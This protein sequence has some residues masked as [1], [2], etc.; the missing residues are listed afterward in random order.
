MYTHTK[1][2]YTSLSF[3]VG[4]AHV[5]GGNFFFQCDIYQKHLQKDQPLAS[6]T[7]LPSAHASSRFLSIA[8]WLHLFNN[9]S[10]LVK[11]WQ[12]RLNSV[13]CS[14]VCSCCFLLLNSNLSQKNLEASFS[15]GN[16]PKIWLN[17]HNPKLP[18]FTC[19]VV[20][21]DILPWT[22]AHLL[23]WVSCSWVPK[24]E[25]FSLYLA[26]ELSSLNS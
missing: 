12:P 8:S 9:S 13:F 18:S 22:F 21:T 26:I 24:S 3:C 11:N 17:L 23:I 5:H 4:C 7:L 15:E 19:N 20:L 1:Q 14:F 16:L 2:T 25:E 10:W 6:R